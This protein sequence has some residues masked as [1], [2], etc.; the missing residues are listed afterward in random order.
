MTKPQNQ[1]VIG[2]LVQF[3]ILRIGEDQQAYHLDE[4]TINT[5]GSHWDPRLQMWRA[6]F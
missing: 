6:S 2:V 3:Y 1:L 5:S 4:K